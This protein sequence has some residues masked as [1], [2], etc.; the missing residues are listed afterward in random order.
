MVLLPRSVDTSRSCSRFHQRHDLGVCSGAQVWQAVSLW[1]LLWY[2]G[3]LISP[4]V[5][6]L[7]LPI[8]DEAWRWMLATGAV[9]AL[10]ILAG[11]SQIPETPRWL[12]SQGRVDEAR[13]VLA[14][15]EQPPDLRVT[16]WRLGGS[17]QVPRDGEGIY[18]VFY[19]AER[20]SCRFTDA[21]NVRFHRVQYD[22]ALVGRSRKL[23]HRLRLLLAGGKG[24][25]PRG[26]RIAVRRKRTAVRGGKTALGLRQPRA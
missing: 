26:D 10:F 8:G 15:A 6:I 5:A 12:L 4:F 7:P 18:Y 19:P 16:D 22:N 9:P 17:H 1:Q 24:A 20:V 2:L 13:E 25:E 21:D 23:G 14:W 11:R 3:A